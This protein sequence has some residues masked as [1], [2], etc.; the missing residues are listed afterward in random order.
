MLNVLVFQPEEVEFKKVLNAMLILI[1]GKQ[2]RLFS[3]FKHFIKCQ[4]RG[5]IFLW[6]RANT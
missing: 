3:E 6:E 1:E 5:K 4:N 2:S